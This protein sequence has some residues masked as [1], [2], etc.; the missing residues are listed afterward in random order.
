M[1]TNKLQDKTTRFVRMT[2]AKIESSV[3]VFKL[4]Y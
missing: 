1:E 4:K 2:L 3:D